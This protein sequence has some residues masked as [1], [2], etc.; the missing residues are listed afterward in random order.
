[1]ILIN[2]IVRYFFTYSA[3]LWA[4]QVTIGDWKLPQP[5]FS[6]KRHTEGGTRTI[7]GHMMSI[8]KIFVRIIHI[9]IWHDIINIFWIS[10]L[11]MQKSD[12]SKSGILL[13][14]P[15]HIVKNSSSSGLKPEWSLER[16]LYLTS[17]VQGLS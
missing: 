5:T 17:C 10:C 2:R 15:F 7:P 9:N 8:T 4:C 14:L 11:K 3:T 16:Y 12:F 6:H 13:F 1:M